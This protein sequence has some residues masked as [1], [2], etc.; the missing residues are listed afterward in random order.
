M[1]PHGADVSAKGRVAKMG[2]NDNDD[3]FLFSKKYGNIKM[4]LTNVKNE[5]I[6]DRMVI[7]IK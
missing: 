1:L 5:Y 7:F 3:V 4:D 6:F 2:T